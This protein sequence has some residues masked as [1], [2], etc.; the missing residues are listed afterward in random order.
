MCNKCK[1]EK[2]LDYGALTNT[3]Y[4]LQELSWAEGHAHLEPKIPIEAR[5]EVPD[6]RKLKVVL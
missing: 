1:A 5:I 4:L 3:N 6:E 2:K